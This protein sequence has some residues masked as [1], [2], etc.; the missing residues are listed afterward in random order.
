MAGETETRK[1]QTETRQILNLMVHSLYSHREIFLR[2][3]IS[4]GSDALDKLRFEALSDPDLLGEEGELEISLEIDKEAR[5]L[6]IHDNGIGMSRDELVAQIGT[7]ARSGTRELWERVQNKAEG[8][9]L[10]GEL[11]GQFGVGFYSAFMVAEKVSLVTRRAG[12]EGATL[13]H[14]DG[15][16]EYSLGDASRDGHGTSVTLHLRD[17]DADKD[18][19]DFTDEATIRRVVKSYSDFVRYPVKLGDDTLNSMKAIWRKPR[20]EVTDDEYAE[21]YKHIAHDFEA[22]LETITFKAEGR[23]E[24]QALLYIPARSPMEFAYPNFKY[25]PQLYVRNVK[26]MDNCEELL[27]RYLRFVRGVVDSSDLPLNVSREILQSHGQLKVVRKGIV[28]KLL[29]ALRTM[30]DKESDK[31]LSFWREFGRVLKEGVAAV[32]ESQDK[33]PPLLM[34]PSSHDPAGLTS[35]ADYVERMKEGQ[36]EIYYLTGESVDIIAGSPQ[37]EAFKAKGIEVLYLADPVDEFM[38]ESLTEFEEHKLKSVGK[39]TVDLGT[40]EEKAAAE[41]AREE[42]GK[43]YSGVLLD[44]EKALADHV[45][46]VRLSNRLTD[47]PVCLVGDDNDLSPQLMRL[48]EQG[49]MAVPKQLRIMELNPDHAVCQNLKDIYRS[50]SQDPRLTNYAEL[51]LGQAFLAE[52]ALPPDPGRFTGLMASLMMG[53]AGAA[54]SSAQSI[55]DEASAD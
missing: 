22:P 31:Y 38:V 42:A 15:A 33:L 5:K 2:E 36:E 30:K 19:D 23:L 11:I 45:K 16:G 12:E 47:S 10:S 44:F 37:L 7:I 6:T 26:I 20:S 49:K 50:D 52:G 17:A 25:G 27:P 53:D 55:E 8:E 40:D 34:F 46:E 21:F 54:S 43:E 24:Y 35:L 1:F 14:S 51:L 48:L 9:G 4:N 29:D 3:L 41:S 39:G 18:L 13:W 28:R 32:E